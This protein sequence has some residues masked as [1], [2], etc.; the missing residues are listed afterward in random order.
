MCLRRTIK[1]EDSLHEYEH[2][3]DGPALSHMPGHVGAKNPYLGSTKESN[4][5]WSDRIASTWDN[6]VQL[7]MKEFR[8]NRVFS[9]FFF[10]FFFK[11]SFSSANVFWVLG[12]VD[13]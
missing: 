4:E 13:S 1:S 2:D 9:F 8:A 10:F 12:F 5:L 7:A 3:N 11:F 6:V